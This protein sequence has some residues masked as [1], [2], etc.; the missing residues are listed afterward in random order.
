M[1]ILTACAAAVWAGLPW[2]AGP[3]PLSAQGRGSAPAAPAGAPAVEELGNPLAKRYPDGSALHYARAI[4]DLQAFD[5]KLYLGHG[6]IALNSG[7]TDVWYYDLR[8]K[9]FV[10]QGRVEDEA[11]DHYRVIGGRLYLPGADPR[12]DWTLGNFYR[13]EGGRW[14]KHRTLPGSVH[15]PDIVG[16]GGSLFAVSARAKPPMCLLESA[17]D[18]KTWTAYD[19]PA[20]DRRIGPRLIVLGGSVYITTWP[21]GGGVNVYRFNGKGFDPCSGD[22]LP[23]AAAPAG[24]DRTFRSWAALEKPTTFKGKVVYIGARH[25]VNFTEKDLARAWPPYTTLGLFVAA[26]AGKDGF[27]AERV[28]AADHLTDIAVDDDRCYVVGYRWASPTDP[29]RGAVSTVWASTDLKRWSELFSVPA[30]TFASAIEVVGGDVYLGLGGTRRFCTPSTG[31]I[32][33][34]GR[35]KPK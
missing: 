8:K 3:A 34:V 12:E 17:D 5:G 16:L 26:P 10:N 14:A 28:L 9:E 32:L 33:R 2:G 27:R 35:A 15:S 31:M 4:S 19:A 20:G 25:R 24:D 21:A 1:R 29:K 11:A 13:L 22:L 18:G 6:D 30:D 7:P 23:G